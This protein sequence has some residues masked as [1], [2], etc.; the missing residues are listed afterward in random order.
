MTESLTAKIEGWLF[1]TG[2]AVAL[3]D[4]TNRF[5]VDM[6]EI[7]GALDELKKQLGNHGISLIVHDDTAQLVTAENLSNLIASLK[8]DEINTD[9][10]RA[11]SEALA[12]IAYLAPVQ[13]LKIDFIRGVNSRA[14]L[15]NLSMRGLVTKQQTGGVTKYSI[16]PEALAHLG[17]TESEA[18]PDYSD[19]REKL[20]QF[21]ESDV[22]MS[23]LDKAV[24][25]E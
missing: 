24:N 16:S 22:V 13:K 18:L 11:Q 1:Y 6:S 23:E 17:V 10:T 9:L 5:G 20:Q 2:E 14:V 3:K 7:K 21:T 4:M 12:V 19:T 8:E 15:R 25:E